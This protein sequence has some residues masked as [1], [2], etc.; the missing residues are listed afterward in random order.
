MAKGSKFLPAEWEEQS[1]VQLTW[2]HGKSDWA[3]YLKDAV[4][5]FVEIAE[6]VLNYEL[7]LIVT[8]E[9]E[10]VKKHLEH[11]DLSK[12]IFVHAD[13]DD[14]WARDHG[15][16][17]IFEDHQPVLLD[18][19]FNGWGGKFAFAK[20]DVITEHMM[21]ANIFSKNTGYRN[22]MDF[23]LEG[24]SIESDGQGTILT[25]SKCLLSANRNITF[26]KG[27]IEKSLLSIFGANR[28]LWLN[29]GQLEG[30]DT[31]G[32]IDTLARF[33]SHDTIA[34]VCSTDPDDSHY[35]ELKMM[36][37]ELCEFVQSNGQPYKLIPLPMADAVYEEGQRLPATYANFLIINGAVLVPFYGS[38]KDRQVVNI[39][40]PL[41]PEMEIIGINCKVLVKQGGSLHCVTMQYPKGVIE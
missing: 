5:C 28:I 10:I 23:I 14:T 41:F 1:A 20:D 13:S 11:C 27:T 3:P 24:G 31:D 12:I 36:E 18:F 29:S 16:I 33:C 38:P 39:L 4:A 22:L 35:K 17:T 30:D 15:P 19:G 8:P 6:N 25:T 21:N 9:V 40:A 7:L 26:F 2:P 37:D 32:H 34:Y